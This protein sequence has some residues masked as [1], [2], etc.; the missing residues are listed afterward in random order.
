[1]DIICSKNLT[2]D[3]SEKRY[4]LFVTVVPYVSFLQIRYPD[5]DV[6]IITEI[7]EI[8]GLKDDDRAILVGQENYHYYEEQF[9]ETIMSVGF[10][11][12][13]V[14]GTLNKL[15]LHFSGGILQKL[16]NTELANE[17][18]NFVGVE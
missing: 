6:K 1:M 12:D 18:G 7:D 4:A 13:S 15:I 8:P 16:E 5:K 10:Y 14:G 11:W 3:D 17:V 9:N 2:F